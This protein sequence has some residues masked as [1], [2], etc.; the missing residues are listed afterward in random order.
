MFM[1][2]PQSQFFFHVQVVQ[3]LKEN[4]QYE[5]TIIAFTTDNGGAANF[6]GNNYPL[7]GTKG[8]LFEGGTRGIAFVH[9]PLLNKKGYISK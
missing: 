5:N 9:S 1:S 7:K 4:G 3:S 8:T 6:G 2:E